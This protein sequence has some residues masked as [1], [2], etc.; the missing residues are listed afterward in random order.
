MPDQ[1]GLH[2]ID[3]LR[4]QEPSVKLIGRRE[5]VS[6][7]PNVAG[8][9]RSGLLYH[10][11]SSRQVPMVESEDEAHRVAAAFDLKSRRDG[12]EA[13]AGRPVYSPRTM[14]GRH[15]FPASFGSSSR[16][17]GAGAPKR[18]H[19]PWPLVSCPTDIAPELRALMKSQQRAFIATMA[20]RSRQDTRVWKPVLDGQG[21]QCFRA[22]STRFAAGNPPSSAYRR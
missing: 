6:K 19:A 15:S 12:D 2:R 20:R 10:R 8:D 14:A 18:T 13:A 1:V 7:L 22:P 3:G 11:R 16:A 9:R 4:G 21:E 17:R 5:G